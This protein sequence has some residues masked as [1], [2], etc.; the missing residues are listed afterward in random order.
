MLALLDYFSCLWRL[1][2]PHFEDDDPQ[3]YPGIFFL[4]AYWVLLVFPVSELQTPALSLLRMIATLLHI[5]LSLVAAII[6]HMAT[7]QIALLV[8]HHTDEFP[9]ARLLK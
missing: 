9:L 7:H 6:L 1:F 8:F 4:L 3:P 2:G 5:M